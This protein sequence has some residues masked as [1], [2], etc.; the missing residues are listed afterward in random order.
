MKWTNCSPDNSGARGLWS[1]VVLTGLAL[2]RV[3]PRL[4]CVLKVVVL[5]RLRALGCFLVTGALGASHE[6]LFMKV[7]VVMGMNFCL[8]MNVVSRV[9][10][11]LKVWPLQIVSIMVGAFLL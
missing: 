11:A 8:V 1:P 3:S 6:R 7:L 5:V 4:T 9:I 10:V 2:L